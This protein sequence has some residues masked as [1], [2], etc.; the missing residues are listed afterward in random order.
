MTVVNY[1]IQCFFAALDAWSG[2]STDGGSWFIG[3]LLICLTIIMYTLIQININ[4]KF[5]R[6]YV[7]PIVTFFICVAIW[8]VFILNCIIG[9]W[10]IKALF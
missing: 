1:L 3:A 7:S 8:C 4:S 6:L 10:L 2:I 9:E 5:F